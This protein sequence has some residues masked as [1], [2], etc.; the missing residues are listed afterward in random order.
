MRMLQSPKL[1]P[2]QFEPELIC[3][4]R[5]V[6]DAAVDQIDAANRTPATKAK[7]AERILRAAA[8]GITDSM[9]L[10]AIAIEDGMQPAD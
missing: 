2:P 1:S 3:T 10:T 7:M 9:T 5:S 6:L 8:E 4:M